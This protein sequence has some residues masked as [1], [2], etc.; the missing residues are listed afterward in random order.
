MCLLLPTS[1]FNPIM[2]LFNLYLL[3]G[4]IISSIVIISLIFVIIKYRYK[5]GDKDPTDTPSLTQF[6]K[7][8]GNAKLPI[9]TVLLFSIILIVLAIQTISVLDL[10]H[11]PPDDPD[12]LDISVKG[13]QWGW[14]FEYPNGHNANEILRIPMGK[15]INLSITSSDVFHNFG[16]YEYRMKMDAIPG[17][18]NHLW[19][20]AEELGEYEI[21]C[22]ELCGSGHT[23]MRGTLKVMEPDEFET[24]YN[25][26]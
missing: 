5:S 9:F 13:Y 10:L 11:H 2:N 26:Q 19:F 3:L 16:I 25:S 1:T 18:T 12:S 15:T 24:W 23:Y 14:N 6:P 17:K 20:M 8:R 7:E 22:F 4:M 21:I